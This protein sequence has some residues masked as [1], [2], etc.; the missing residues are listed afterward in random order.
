MN[1]RQS[2]RDQD[3]DPFMYERMREME[4]MKQ[5]PRRDPNWQGGDHGQPYYHVQEPPFMEHRPPRKSKF[6]TVLFAFLFP[7]LG[8][9]YLGLMQ[10]GLLMMM[11]LALDIVAMVYF[12]ENMGANVPLIVLLSLLIPVVYFYNL[13]DAMQHTEKVNTAALYGTPYQVKQEPWLGAIL[14]VIGMLL[15]LFAFDPSWLRFVFHNAG[16]FVGAAILI[17]GGIF[18]LFRERKSRP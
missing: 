17:L 11:L 15:F 14:I 6:V 10:R 9:F 18:L 2:S 13:F 8:H 5:N 12:I 1:R 16:S 4:E 3:H 7:G